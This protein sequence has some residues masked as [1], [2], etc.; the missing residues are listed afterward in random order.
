MRELVAVK[1]G[2]KQPWDIKQ[3]ATV[4]MPGSGPGELVTGGAWN[5]VRG[6][7]YLVRYLPAGGPGVIYVY[8]ARGVGNGGTP[9]PTGLRAD[10]AGSNVTLSWR[11]PVGPAVTDFVLEAG[12]GP[13]QSNLIAGNR[14]GRIDTVTA[15]N[16]P[17]GTYYV[18]V[19]SAGSG[20]LS[21]PSNEVVAVVGGSGGGGGGLPGTPDGF[22]A[23][24]DATGTVTIYWQP[25]GGGGAPTSYLLEAGTA[26]GLTNIT[27]G[28]QLPLVTSFSA[29]AVPSGTYYLRMRA[30]NA[31]GRGA[32]TRDIGVVVP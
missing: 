10:V 11:A 26:P 12:T 28:I 3:Y 2:L 6:E 22:Q 32:P 27:D 23:V 24:A 31:S 1:R 17:K 4:D 20:G 9:P 30:V 14:V 16:V 7:Y 18:R 8:S 5:P 29:R 15:Q 21:V 19:R 13:G 25:P